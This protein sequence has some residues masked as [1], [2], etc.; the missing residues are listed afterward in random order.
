MH[1]HVPLTQ[2][3]IRSMHHVLVALQYEEACSYG[4]LIKCKFFYFTLWTYG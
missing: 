1:L 3:P 2:V 4:V